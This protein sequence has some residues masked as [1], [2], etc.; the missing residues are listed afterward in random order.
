MTSQIV[1]VH[2]VTPKFPALYVVLPLA[3]PLEAKY[4]YYTSDAVQF[5]VLWTLILYVG[6]HLVTALYAVIAQWPNWKLVWAM[7][8]LY[9]V[10]A[11][12]EALLAG[13]IVGALSVLA[14]FPHIYLCCE[15]VHA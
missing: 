12:L 5:T 15:Y 6:T 2:Y 8:L 14:L 9:G 11:G 7:P 13:S 3:S 1:P 4:L 10:V